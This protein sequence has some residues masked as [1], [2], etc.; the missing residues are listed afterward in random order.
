MQE[1]QSSLL[2]EDTPGIREFH[3]PSLIASKQLKSMLFFEVGDLLAER[4]LGDVQS[5]RSP[6]EVPLF[7]QDNDG[8]QVA[9]FNLSEHGS[10]SFSPSGRDWLLPYI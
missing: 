7:G 3:N 2:D 6:R 10:T 8:L 4:G 1:R 9:D 5:V